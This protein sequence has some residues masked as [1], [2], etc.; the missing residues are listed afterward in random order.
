VRSK[1][2][3]HDQEKGRIYHKDM[4]L[5]IAGVP[6]LRL[7]YLSHP[8]PMQPRSTGLL[9]PSVDYSGK[10]GVGVKIPYFFNLAPNYDLTLK[11]VVYSR[12]GL[13]ARAIWRHNVGPGTYEVDAGGIYQLSRKRFS[14]PG[15][16]RWR[17][18]ARAEG[19]FDITSRWQWGFEGAVQSDRAMMRTYDI[20]SRDMIHSRLWIAGLDGRNWFYGETG[21]FRGLRDADTRGHDPRALPWL[22]H[23]YTFAPEIMGGALTLSAPAIDIGLDWRTS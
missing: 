20:D 12:Q 4:T 7:P 10:L 16:R 2:A 18:Y 13:L 21:H 5:E 1:Q 22:E 23:E 11:P 19:R 8:D 15:R 17:G 6:L 14:G 9:V 3:T